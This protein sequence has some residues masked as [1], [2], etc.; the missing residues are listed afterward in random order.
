MNRKQLTLLIVLGVVVG[1]LGFYVYNKRQSSYERGSETDHG[2]KVLKG[3]APGS[4]NDVAQL[5]IKQGSNEVNLLRASDG[6]IVKERGGYPANFSTISD[7]VKKFWDLKVTRPVDVGPSRLP[8]LKLTKDEGT[9]VDFKDDKGKSIA[10]VTLGLQTSKE[11]GEESPFGGGS[12]PNGR[13]VMRGDDVKTIALISDPLSVDAKPE[14]WLN[15]DWLKVEKVKSVSVVTT[16]A[17]NNWKLVRESENGDWKLADAKAG[18]STDSGKA[19]GLNYLLSSP[20]FNDVIVDPKPDKIGLDH[21]TTA[22]IET[23]E[24][25]TYTIKLGKWAGT[26]DNY[27]FQM[28][29]AGNFPKERTPGKDEKKEDKEKLDKEFADS[30]KKLEDKLKNEKQFE[31]WTYNVSKW[32]VDNLLKERKDFLAEKKEEPKAENTTPGE[33]KPGDKQPA[34]KP[35]AK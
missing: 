15:K 12:F 11:S 13:Y 6:W 1:G 26:E 22:T 30:R 34:V 24:G 2:Q 31:K 29:V 18:E 14:D 7:T 17:T 33:E 20:T 21:P 3:L 27:A 4:I 35:A 8:R 9:L 28:S 10:S 5:T 32:T 23:F 25:F 16:N 19:S